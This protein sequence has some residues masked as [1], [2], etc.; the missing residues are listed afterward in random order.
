MTPTAI[1]IAALSIMSGGNADP[2]NVDQILGQNKAEIVSQVRNL[3]GSRLSM[4]RETVDIL[5]NY[6]LGIKAQNLVVLA[7]ASDPL[8][9]AYSTD[10]QDTILL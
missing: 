8:G 10:P 4:I 5:A 1:I 9:V 2:M 7:D 3:Q 6:D